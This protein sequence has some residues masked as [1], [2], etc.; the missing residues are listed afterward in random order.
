MRKIVSVATVL[1]SMFVSLEHAQAKLP[2]ADVFEDLS[3]KVK[4][5]FFSSPQDHLLPGQADKRAGVHQ[6]AATPV[7]DSEIN[8]GRHLLGRLATKDKTTKPA[9]A[10]SND[11]DRIDSLLR[12]ITIAQMVADLKGSA[13]EQMAAETDAVMVRQGIGLYKGRNS[14]D[15]VKATKAPRSL[16]EYINAWNAQ[17]PQSPVSTSSQSAKHLPAPSSSSTEVQADMEHLNAIAARNFKGTSY[18][19]T[20]DL[21][22]KFAFTYCIN[23]THATLKAVKG[24]FKQTD[25]TQASA[26]L[27]YIPH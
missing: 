23:P 5:T 25:I 27:T 2:L 20:K 16:Q 24:L 10:S 21:A 8:A 9:V 22:F 14:G 19:N 3:T 26:A 18:N 13:V 4:R 7:L 11:S 12:K 15:G 6:V 17:A 1:V